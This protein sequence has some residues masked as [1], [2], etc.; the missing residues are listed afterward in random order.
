ML[1]QYAQV[2]IDF[3]PVIL[4]LQCPISQIEPC[5]TAFEI[6]T[7]SWKKVHKEEVQP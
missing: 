3:K 4:I 1:E 5:V 6:I 2:S 7:V